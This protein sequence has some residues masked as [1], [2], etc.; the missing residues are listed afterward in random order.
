[1]VV[2]DDVVLSA[3]RAAKKT[4]PS[5]GAKTK[6]E[7]KVT[8]GSGDASSLVG[9]LIAYSAQSGEELWRCPT[10]MGYNS[11]PDVFVS[12]GLV[13]TGSA[14]K[15]T[16]ED[17]T[18]GRDLHTGEVKR[19]FVTD[20]LFSVA[21]H[22]RCYR[23]KAT[24]R[25][26]VLGRTGVE[27]IDTAEGELVRDCWVRGACQ[28]GVMPANGLLYTPPH[29]CACYIQSKISGFVALAPKRIPT[30][31]ARVDSPADERLGSAAKRE[32][33]ALATGLAG[34][35]VSIPL[36]HLPVKISEQG[37]RFARSVFLSRGQPL[38]PRDFQR[39]GSG[40]Q[41]VVQ[42]GR[43]WYFGNRLAKRS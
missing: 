13:W 30:G 20:S 40:V 10:A 39:H 1:V 7:W 36:R 33:M 15:R 26:I 6:I 43:Y 24:D 38:Q 8:A 25:F 34:R 23:N 5:A 29:S 37:S 11:P 32:P 31:G 4:A 17:F 22:H 16:K 19:R 12:G 27:L 3:D 18:E 14:P 41:R 2:K 9:E 21:H 28:Y 35:N 42:W